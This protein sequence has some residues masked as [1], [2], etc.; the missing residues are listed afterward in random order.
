ME[1]DQNN[2]AKECLAISTVRER[3]GS[4]DI[5][6]AL[7]R[8]TIFDKSLLIAQTASFLHVFSRQ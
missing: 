5:W 2:A 8:A 7:V 3:R 1:I 4:S 6:V